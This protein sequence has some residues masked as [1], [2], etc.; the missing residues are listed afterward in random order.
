MEHLYWQLSKVSR[1]SRQKCLL[2]LFLFL[3][4]SFRH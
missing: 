1:V 2:T 4:L 3:I